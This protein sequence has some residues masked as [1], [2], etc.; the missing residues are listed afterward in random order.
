MSRISFVAVAMVL[1][2]VMV[3]LVA[4]AIYPSP[5]D[6]GA[7]TREITGENIGTR[8]FGGLAESVGRA[9]CYMGSE[10]A[11]GSVRVVGEKIVLVNGKP[12]IPAPG[13]WLVEVDGRKFRV[14]HLEVIE[15]LRK[16]AKVEVEG[17]KALVFLPGKGR[18]LVLV[19]TEVSLVVDGRHATM[20]WMGYPGCEDMHGSWGHG[21]E[22]WTPGPGEWWEGGMG[23]MRQHGS[24]P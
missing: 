8:P 13:Y 18:V 6:I 17:H 5:P 3:P 10:T 22:T 11:S 12:V 4:Y 7:V 21:E 15:A 2:A 9:V 19:A 1:A 20:H 24:C 16:A 14:T 23:G